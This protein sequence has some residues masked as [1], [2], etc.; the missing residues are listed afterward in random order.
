MVPVVWLTVAVPLVPFTSVSSDCV[1][2]VHLGSPSM[3]M[4][5]ASSAQTC[6]GCVGNYAQVSQNIAKSV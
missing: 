5:P 2:V 1:C 6:A 4:S 3:V